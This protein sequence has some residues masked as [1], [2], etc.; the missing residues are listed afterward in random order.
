M[1]REALAADPELA[2]AHAVLS[3]ALFGQGRCKPALQAAEQALA[4]EPSAEAF[5]AQALALYGLKRRK[6]AVQ[7]GRKAVELSP[8]SP[9][10]ANIFGLV[11][12]Q[13]GRR[14]EA[15]R[16]FERAMTLAPGNDGFRGQYG[17]FLLRQKQLAAAERVAAEL[18]PSSD[19]VAAL[20]L[21]GGIA[22]RRHRAKE[23]EDL[24]LWVLSRDAVNQSALILLTQAKAAKSRWLGLWWRY[25]VFI[26]TK[27]FWLRLLV[28]V[29][30]I[31]VLCGLFSWAGLLGFYYMA[32]ARGVFARMVRR[33]LQAVTENVRLKKGF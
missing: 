29:P 18:D 32:V 9:S 13:A 1:A 11:L 23:A 28:M 4:I 30:L 25:N 3:L 14:A 8:T 19:H 2:G 21:R 10:S 17:L 22:V 26:G 33:E 31:L 27:P 6:D 7:A 5:R 15:R 24:A 20:L 16:A 12:E